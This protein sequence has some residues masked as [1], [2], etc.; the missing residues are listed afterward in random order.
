[1][2]FFVLHDGNAYSLASY[3]SAI[4]DTKICS[5]TVNVKFQMYYA[6]HTEILLS[7]ISGDAGILTI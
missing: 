4:N 6:T 5:Q 3:L 2:Y 7:D 1:M